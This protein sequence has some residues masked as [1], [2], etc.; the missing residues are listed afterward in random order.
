MK[1]IHVNLYG[2]K[3]IFGGKETPLEADEIYCD[4]SEQCSFYKEGKC[5]RCRSFLAP[6]CKFGRNSITKGY[7]SRAKKYNEFKSKYKNDEVY[8]KLEYPTRLAAVIGDTLYMNLK[9]T[10]VRKKR[11]E[12]KTYSRCYRCVDG[13]EI[14]EVGFSNGS[15]FIPFADIT[16][17]LLYGIFSYNPQAMMGGVITKYQEEV[18]PEVLQDLK[19]VAPD[20]YN[21]FIAEYPKYDIATNYIG[22]KAYVNSLKPGTIF[23]YKG[24]DW[25]YDGEYVST[26][27]F[28]L[29]LNSPW[30]TDGKYSETVKIKVSDK[31]TIEIADNSIVDEDTRFY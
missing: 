26:E 11:D 31:M 2:G 19:K 23:R 4:R 29:G 18:V 5:L 12:E 24:Y 22:K 15:C 8:G 13:Y 1:K 7:T 20:I 17:D 25:L 6:T 30:W 21:K 16:N 14:S 27:H 3:G 28:D 9:F 10:L